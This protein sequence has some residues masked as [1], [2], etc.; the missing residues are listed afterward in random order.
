MRDAVLRSCDAVIVMYSVIAQSSFNDVPDLR[1]QILRAEVTVPTTLV[2]NK[3]D[4][5]ESRTITAEQG[6]ILAEKFNMGF[7]EISAKTN[8]NVTDLMFDLA[9]QV[10]QARSV[11]Q[12]PKKS[13]KN[14][15]GKDCKLN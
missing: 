4:L 1:E 13:A 6:K 2:A 3:Q 5:D 12:K 9:R 14:K 8:H 11:K 15:A 10:V 7:Y